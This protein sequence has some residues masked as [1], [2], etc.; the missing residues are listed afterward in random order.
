MYYLTRAKKRIASKTHLQ[1]LSMKNNIETYIPLLQQLVPSKNVC[2]HVNINKGRKTDC[3]E[4]DKRSVLLLC[5]ITLLSV[6]NSRNNA[7]IVINQV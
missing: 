7:F 3:F 5:C 6:N 1:H 4:Q 2:T